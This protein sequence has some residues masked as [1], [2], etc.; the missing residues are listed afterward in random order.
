MKISDQLD[1]FDKQKISQAKFKAKW[2]TVT[3]FAVFLGWIAGVVF[4]YFFSWYSYRFLQLYIAT[5]KE[6]FVDTCG[7]LILSCGS[8]V[9]ALMIVVTMLILV[10]AIWMRTGKDRGPYFYI[11][12]G[13]LIFRTR[14]L[15]LILNSRESL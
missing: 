3:L 6:A 4:T 9:G 14:S 10:W 15:R 12:D 11:V 1:P 2:G 5:D 8:A 7:Y 13:G